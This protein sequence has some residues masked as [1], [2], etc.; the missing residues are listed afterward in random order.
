ME[1]ATDEDICN[2]IQSVALAMASEECE[3]E[4]N[5]RWNTLAAECI[6][7]MPAEELE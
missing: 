5:V 6:A 1:D 7:D 3:G 2:A 4:D